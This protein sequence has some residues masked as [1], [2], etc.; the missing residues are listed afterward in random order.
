MPAGDDLRV[1]TWNVHGCVGGDGRYDGSRA[2]GVLSEIDADI[3]ALQE[4]PSLALH[5]ELMRD[6]QAKLGMHIAL[7]RTLS[8][9]TR[10]SATRYCHAI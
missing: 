7:G 3:V 9:A 10:I 5:A 1:A 2:I 4:V 6:I 8:D